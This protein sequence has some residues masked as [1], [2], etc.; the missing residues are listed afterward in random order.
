MSA[1]PCLVCVCCQVNAVAWYEPA[2][3]ACRPS[4]EATGLLGPASTETDTADPRIQ[5]GPTDI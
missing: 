5:I 3:E 1:S 4:L 2:C